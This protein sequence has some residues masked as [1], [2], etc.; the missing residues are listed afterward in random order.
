MN[1]VTRAGLAKPAAAGQLERGVG[2]ARCLGD[3]TSTLRG[4]L[5]L[6]FSLCCRGL[7]LVLLV[8]QRSAVQATLALLEV[9]DALAL[10]AL[11]GL[12]ATVELR[13]GA[14]DCTG[15]SC[16]QEK[17]KGA[18]LVAWVHVRERVVQELAA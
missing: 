12:T 6:L 4:R 3:K 8:T 13:T 7:L 14:A 9:L 2:L 18:C 11:P 17:C 16:E 10:S 15:H 5:E 1:R